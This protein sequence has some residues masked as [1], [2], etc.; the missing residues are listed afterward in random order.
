MAL[1][2]ARGLSY[3]HGQGVCHGDLKLTNCLL[4]RVAPPGCSGEALAAAAAAAGDDLSDS[5]AGWVPKVRVVRGCPR[6]VGV[7]L[8]VVHGPHWQAMWVLGRPKRQRR[9]VG[10]G[11]NGRLA[12]LT[13]PRPLDPLLLQ[14]SQSSTCN[15]STWPPLACRCATSA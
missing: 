11:V 1:G 15:V 5:L 10:P 2:I 13:G 6:C 3:I 8:R 7:E 9:R 14:P 12:S 4:A